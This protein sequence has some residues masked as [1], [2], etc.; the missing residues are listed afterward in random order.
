[1][2][3]LC[4]RL[5][6]PIQIMG[7]LVVVAALVLI[8][9]DVLGL[10]EMGFAGAALVVAGV[11]LIMA[12][13]VLSLAAPAARGEPLELDAPVAGPWLAINSPATKVPSHGT[14]GY[15]QAYAVDLL[16]APEG[17]ERPRFGAAGAFLPPERFPAFG[18]R[19]HA[20]ADG[21]VVRAVDGIRDHRSR[22]SW[23]GLAWFMLESIVRELRGARGMLGNHVVLR[24]GDGSHFAIAHLRRGSI[25]VAVGDEVAA[26]ALLAECGN[27][28]SSTEPHVHCQRQDVADASRAA[29]LPWTI[30]GTG[31]PANEETAVLT[32]ARR[33]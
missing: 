7:V 8:A 33:A 15:G 19:V 20:P 13:T 29:G 14:H 1:M 3:V 17:V 31:M 25:V 5:R 21:V 2:A 28:G 24:L 10:V 30:R 9:A 12:S 23:L 27:T 6:M 16:F 26:G 22:S 18:Q 11:V 4:A 32:T